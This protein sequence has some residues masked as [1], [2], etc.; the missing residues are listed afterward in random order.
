LAD[1]CSSSW[2]YYTGDAD[3]LDIQVISVSAAG[4]NPIRFNYSD[5]QLMKISAIRLPITT[6][7]YVILHSA[8]LDER[9]A[10]LVSRSVLQP[11]SQGNITD[12]FDIQSISP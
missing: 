2:P 7:N 6:A 12:T 3:T 5:L 11:T 1:Q 4:V 8:Q 10:I 9:R